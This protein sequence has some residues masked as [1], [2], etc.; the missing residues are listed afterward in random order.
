MG[1]NHSSKPM[2]TKDLL[3]VS[4]AGNEYR[5][6]FA[7]RSDRPLAARVIGTVENHIGE[8]RETLDDALEAIETDADDFK[9]V[10]GFASLLERKST[11]ETRAPIEPRRARRAVF[12]AAEAIGVESRDDRVLA[13]VRAGEALGVSA[14]DLETASERCLADASVVGFRTQGE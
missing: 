8:P 11:Y 12:E 9:L 5:P 10:R 7:G 6:Q 4:R 14:D 1:T 13:F 2:L 3:R